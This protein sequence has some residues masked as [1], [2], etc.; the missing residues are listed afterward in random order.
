LFAVGCREAR[1]QILATAGQ[2]QM[3]LSA[4]NAIPGTLCEA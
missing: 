3:D 2:V 4:V 1:Q